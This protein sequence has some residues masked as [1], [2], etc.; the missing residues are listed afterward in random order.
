MGPV[1]PAR[2]APE[3]SDG[4][5]GARNRPSGPKCR[6]CSALPG[7]AAGVVWMPRIASRESHGHCGDRGWGN[8]PLTGMRSAETCDVHLLLGQGIPRRL[9]R[10]NMKNKLALAM[11]L[12]IASSP[13]WAQPAA[14][15]PATA[16]EPQALRDPLGRDTPRGALLGF[17]RVCRE[18]NFEA[19]PE[20]LNTTLRGLPAQELARQLLRRPRQAAAGA[21][22]RA[23]RPAGGPAHQSAETR[24]GCSRH[25][26][27]VDGQSQHRGRA[28]PA[29][30]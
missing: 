24:R 8:T 12:L 9:G 29:R 20:Y 15:A 26:H 5:S 3:P 28:R 22:R 23:Q 19:A 7:F 14:T 25:D 18:G 6:S 2:R 27:H 4:R 11:M 13:A 10:V 30:G 17:M 21:P 1:Q 16:A